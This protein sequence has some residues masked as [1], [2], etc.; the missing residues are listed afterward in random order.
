MFYSW[1]ACA[2]MQLP[3]VRRA[4]PLHMER[5]S[6]VFMV[7][8]RIG[9]STDLARLTEQSLF[10]QGFIED[11]VRG[12]FF[13]NCRHDTSTKVLRGMRG[14]SRWWPRKLSGLPPDSA[15]G[16]ISELGGERVVGYRVPPMDDVA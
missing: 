6:V 5:F 7:A 11:G 9:H 16:S 8:I 12:E 15:G 4:E 3:M 2:G 13:S 14:F 10:T 1:G